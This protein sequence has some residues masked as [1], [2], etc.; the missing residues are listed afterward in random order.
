MA[1]LIPVKVGDETIWVEASESAAVP[2]QSSIQEAASPREAAEK[3]LDTAQ[4]LTSS[5]RAFSA[6]VIDGLATRGER[7]RPTKATIEFGVNVSVEGNVYVVKGS[8]GASVKVVAE[9]DLG[10]DPPSE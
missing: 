2:G 1:E 8:G 4:Q 9:W 10:R 7:G 3:A 5:I 6:S